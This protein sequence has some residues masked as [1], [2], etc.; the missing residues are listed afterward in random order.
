MRGELYH[1]QPPPTSPYLDVGVRDGGR[2]VEEQK[3]RGLQ[4]ERWE[5]GGWKGGGRDDWMKGSGSCLKAAGTEGRGRAG[6]W[7]SVGGWHTIGKE[8]P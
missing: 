2:V 6:C 8:P 5:R 7:G 3:A 1:V 4:G